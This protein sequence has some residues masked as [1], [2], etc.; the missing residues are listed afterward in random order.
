MSQDGDKHKQRA[1]LK[2]PES[3]GSKKMQSP[4]RVGDKHGRSLGC[5]PPPSVSL[6]RDRF[7]QAGLW[8]IARGQRVIEGQQLTVIQSRELRTGWNKIRSGHLQARRGLRR[9]GGWPTAQGGANDMWVV[10]VHSPS[11]ITA[12][13]SFPTA[14]ARGM[15][16]SAVP[17][18]RDGWSLEVRH[19]HRLLSEVVP[20][21]ALLTNLPPPPAIGGG[22][23][24][25][26]AQQLRSSTPFPPP[27]QHLAMI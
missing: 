19:L 5:V 1:N 14:N 15:G 13:P 3:Y 16:P 8:R 24:G 7:R 26:P 21:G 27:P 22:M 18:P 11:L 17:L 6:A 23:S 25:G 9:A 2:V 12:L 10:G 20:I 4:Q